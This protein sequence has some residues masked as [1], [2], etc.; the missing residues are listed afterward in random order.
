ME[1]G[2]EKEVAAVTGGEEMGT[3]AAWGATR[4]DGSGEG[5]GGGNRDEGNVGAAR[6]IGGY[7]REKNDSC[8][9]KRKEARS[10]V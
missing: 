1:G 5:V 7:E 3:K 4:A 9:T 2:E 10:F 6:A 8:C